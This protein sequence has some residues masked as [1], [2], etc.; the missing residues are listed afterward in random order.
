MQFSGS[1]PS[2]VAQSLTRRL[3]KGRM[4]KDFVH[5]FVVSPVAC[6]GKGP[7]RYMLEFLRRI[8][9]IM[10]LRQ[11]SLRKQM[12]QTKRCSSC[13]RRGA[14]GRDSCYHCARVGY[15]ARAPPFRD[16]VARALLA[17]LA[18]RLSP[19]P[20]LPPQLRSVAYRQRDLRAVRAALASRP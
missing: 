4:R 20:H 19:S 2:R 1:K 7:S 8:L 11:L 12:D 9:F 14:P 3:T 6:Q 10:P 17:R 13:A 16:F 18:G 5:E 15:D